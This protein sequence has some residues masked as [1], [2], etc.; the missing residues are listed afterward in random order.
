[1]RA[2]GRAPHT[3]AG[4]MPRQSARGA[5]AR[6]RGGKC[7]ESVVYLNLLGNRERARSAVAISWR[8]FYVRPEHA[9]N[10]VEYSRAR[11]HWKL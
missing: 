1:M 6:W 7:A 10:R 4:E 8:R 5:L 2:E 3:G 9:I 11:V